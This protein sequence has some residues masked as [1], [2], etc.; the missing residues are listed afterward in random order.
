[1]ISMALFFQWIV[2]CFIWLSIQNNT[3]G[4]DIE[5]FYID[6]STNDNFEKK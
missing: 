2:E 6:L 3:V 5:F 1:M 4:Y